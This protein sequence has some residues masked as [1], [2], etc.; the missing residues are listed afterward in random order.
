MIEYK[1]P[2]CGYSTLALEII[3]KCEC[4]KCHCLMDVNEE[5]E[6]LV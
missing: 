1:C 4:H 3:I 5:I 6:D 2:S